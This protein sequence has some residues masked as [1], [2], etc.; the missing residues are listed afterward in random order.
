MFSLTEA[1]SHYDKSFIV[2]IQNVI[3]CI[4]LFQKILFNL[5]WHSYREVVSK[6][7]IPLKIEDLYEIRILKKTH[8]LT[9]G[10]LLSKLTYFLSKTI[11][12]EQLL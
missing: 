4:R 11:F 1:N 8:L 12:G 6:N 5:I 10:N 7:I 2:A 3:L 9:K